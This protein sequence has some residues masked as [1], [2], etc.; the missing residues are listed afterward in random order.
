MEEKIYEILEEIDEEIP[1]Y[2][3]DLFEAGLLDSF[4]VI[5]IVS[6]LED[7]FD[8]EIDAKYVIMKNFATKDAIVS[9]IQRLL[10]MA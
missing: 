4:G 9:L 2:E 10:E 5:E 3:G 1:S 8:I 6:K 7:I